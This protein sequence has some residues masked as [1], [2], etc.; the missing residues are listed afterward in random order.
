MSH[1]INYC[2]V[3]E[4]VAD[5]KLNG[6]EPR[7]AQRIREASQ[8]ILRHLGRFL[9]VH[10]T[11]VLD[12]VSTETLNFP[13]GLL[14]LTQ[15]HVDGLAVTDFTLY[16]RSRAWEGGPYTWAERDAGWGSEVEIEGDWGLYE[17]IEELG[18]G[19]DQAEGATTLTLAD[20]SLLSPGMVLVL[21]DEQEFVLAGNGG[22][23]SP[24]ASAAGSTLSAA[25]D[26]MV[27]EISVS[28]PGEFFEGETLQIGAE[29]LS[30][31]KIGA[32]SIITARGWNGTTK[33]AHGL[34]SPI[35][36]YRTY[37]VARGANG[38][39]ACSHTDAALLRL[40]PPADVHWLALQ[41]AALMRQKALTAFGGKA[42][43]TDQGEA[44]YVNEFPRQIADIREN[45][46]IPY[47]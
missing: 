45:Y 8:F 23:R 30:V 12:G 38:T 16:P 27:E 28:D 7:L 5:L 41:I 11:R 15:V 14:N 26:L 19:A 40:R 29:D 42:G 20:G 35:G 21:D 36:V 32:A 43:N 3:G 37:Q 46:A 17:E 9:P 47:L 10:E 24:G 25:I 33:T 13:T 44:F 6:D 39:D 1:S 34:G 2:T 4:L 22:P 18:L 31:R